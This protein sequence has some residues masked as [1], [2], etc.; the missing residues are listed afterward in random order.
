M[1][2][3]FGLLSSEQYH[4]THHTIILSHI[5]NKE[6]GNI[7]EGAE[8]QNMLANKQMTANK[9]VNDWIEDKINF[10]FRLIN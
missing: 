4:N 6:T 3:Y 1:Q 7:L 8:A 9:N 5:T 2:I 10:G